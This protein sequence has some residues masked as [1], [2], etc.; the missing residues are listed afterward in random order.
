MV[1]WWG[2]WSVVTVAAMDMAGLEA[3]CMGSRGIQ[4]LKEEVGT[5]QLL[6]KMPVARAHDQPRNLIF[7]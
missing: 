2:C 1:T 3:R 5:R 7:C 4:E 6:M